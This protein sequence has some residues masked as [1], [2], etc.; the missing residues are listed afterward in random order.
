[1][2]SMY[3]STKQNTLP[4]PP[5]SSIQPSLMTN[6]QHKFCGAIIRNLKRHRDAAPF[7]KPVDYVKLNVPDYPSIVQH[8]MDLSIVHVKLT[9]KEYAH[10]NEFISDVRLIFNNCYKFNGPEALVS[11][12]CQNVESAFE[13]S[14]RQM[15][16]SK[17]VEEVLVEEEMIGKEPSPPLSQHNSPPPGDTIDLSSCRP[18]REIHCPSK[19]YP[20]TFTTQR[21]LSL[22]NKTTQMKYC[23]Q[24]IKEFKKNKYRDQM[25]PFLLPVDPIALNIP[26]YPTIVKHPMDLSTIENKLLND[27]YKGPSQFQQDVKLMFDNCYLYN[28][29]TLPIYSS[30]Q[31]M[32]K[33]FD[34]KW[35]QRPTE[36]EVVTL[37]K[38]TS[39]KQPKKRMEDEEE[40]ELDEES[41]QEDDKLAQLERHLQTI[42]QQ[43]E[44][45]KKPT[46]KKSSPPPKRKRVP[47]KKQAVV[48]SESEDEELD[49]Y[50]HQQKVTLS[51]CI[52]GLSADKLSGVV[53]I[54]Q[55]NMPSL[56]GNGNNEIELDMESLDSKTL[57][58]LH[59]YVFPD[60]QI[61]FKQPQQPKRRGRK[62][63]PNSAGKRQKRE[64]FSEDAAERKIKALEA[65]LKKFKGNDSSSSSSSESED[66][67]DSSSSSD[68]D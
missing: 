17:H 36:E 61:F 43:I 33:V 64:H 5:P 48:E 14:L 6:E 29:P 15:P 8:P 32:E 55:A 11:V 63:N 62:P 38:N 50:G 39:K 4:S 10:V 20:Q 34:D 19:D 57:I 9:A 2:F 35:E 16:Y 52:N 7:L 21:K 31:H 51:E 37:V 3:N 53:E 49:M 46:S 47:K 26:D 23:F 67:G 65:T 18:K 24:V 30:A 40:D 1:M 22:A 41:E 58:Q 59:N 56:Q 12:L 13:K 44:S 66:D 68:S 45:M 60:D 54:I 28:P 25:Y 42:T 27:E